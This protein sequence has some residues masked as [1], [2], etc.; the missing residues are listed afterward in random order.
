MDGKDDYLD[1]VRRKI[2]TIDFELVKLLNERVELAL[3]TKRFKERISD[4]DREAEVL[5]R[6]RENVRRYSQGL[7]DSTFSSEFFSLIMTE[8]KRV[9][10]ERSILM[11]FQGEHGAYGEVAVRSYSDKAVPIP[12]MEFVD[13]FEGVELGLY[14]MGMVPVENSLEGGVTEVNDLLIRRDVKVVGEIR[15]RINHCLLGLPGSDICDVRKVYSHPQALAQCRDYL[16]SRGM[17]SRPIYD[18]AGAAKMLVQS[19]PEATAVISSRLCAELY[20]LDILDDSVEDESSNMTRFLVISRPDSDMA[21]L[22]LPPTPGNKCSIVFSTNHESGSLF[23]MLKIF[24]ESQLN[25]TRIESRPVRDD[26]GRYNFLL[27]FMGNP[28]EQ[29]VKDALEKVEGGAPFYRFLGCY[30]QA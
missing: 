30:P 22:S 27:D 14:D 8:S 20:H 28:E 18:T 2:D 21:S 15:I 10:G 11:A 17:E 29:R 3:R 5:E 9:Q 16:Q 24:S 26:P 13:V 19:R 12:C 7:I 1:D 6:A 23:E 25:L 4:P